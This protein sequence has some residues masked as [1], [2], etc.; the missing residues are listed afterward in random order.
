MSGYEGPCQLPISQ[1]QCAKQVR[2]RPPTAPC[3]VA[4]KLQH[5]HTHT[6]SDFIQIKQASREMEAKHFEIGFI[7]YS[8]SVIM[9]QTLKSP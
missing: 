4:G 9:T 7:T 5:T 6:C 2:I 8:G 1:V 3:N